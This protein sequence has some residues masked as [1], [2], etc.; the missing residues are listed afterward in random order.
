MKR[1]LK[2]HNINADVV[3]LFEFVESAIRLREY[4]KF[5][6]TKSL[7][8]FL[9]IFAN[10]GAQYGLNRE[11]LSFA[12]VGIIKEMRVTS[13]PVDE[14]LVS[15]V[16]KGKSEYSITQLSTLPPLIMS[17]KDAWYIKWPDT[18]SNFITT[19]KITSDL[20]VL[21]KESDIE[22]KIVCIEGADPGYDWIFL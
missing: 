17:P 8:E 20:I 5:E 6:F 2:K 15:S 10:F 11:E 18:Q 21:T 22:G 7:S 12:S 4:A 13:L 16:E 14:L 3:Q 19:K 1:L 9:E